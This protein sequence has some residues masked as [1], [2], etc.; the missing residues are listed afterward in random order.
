MMLLAVHMCHG[1][2]TFVWKNIVGRICSAVSEVE[3]QPINGLIHL[4]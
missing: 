2:H 1:Q 3:V 4:Q